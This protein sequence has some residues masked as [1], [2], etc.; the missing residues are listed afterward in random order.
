[1][2]WLMVIMA[3]QEGRA[4]GPLGSWGGC[5]LSTLSV[6]VTPAVVAARWQ[7]PSKTPARGPTAWGKAVMWAHPPTRDVA[8]RH[9]ATACSIVAG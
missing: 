7:A 2:A 8:A 6:A 5:S 9:G 4:L 1:M 3:V